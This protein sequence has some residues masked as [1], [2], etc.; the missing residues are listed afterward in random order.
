[1]GRER[2]LDAST[3]G[4]S[5]GRSQGS[6]S[7]V[8]GE[9]EAAAGALVQGRLTHPLGRQAL[10]TEDTKRTGGVHRQV[11]TLSDLLDGLFFVGDARTI[12][13][14]NTLALRFGLPAELET[15]LDTGVLAITGEDDAEKTLH[16]VVPSLRQKDRKGRIKV[17]TITWIHPDYN[18]QF[19][20]YYDKTPGRF[21]EL[22][23]GRKKQRRAG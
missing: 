1:M 14:M 7:H 13:S 5:E 18:A 20:H 15:L 4:L 12:K 2:I 19:C 10:N 21:A 11:I 22:L 17:V 9:G 23:C 6:A 16:L 3:A 8:P